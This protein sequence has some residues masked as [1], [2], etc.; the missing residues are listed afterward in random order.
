M[1]VSQDAKLEAELKTLLHEGG[2][3]YPVSTIACF[4]DLI[5]D[6]NFAMDELLAMDRPVI[7]EAV[8]GPRRLVLQRVR[9]E[10]RYW[11]TS[12]R[13]PMAKTIENELGTVASLADAVALCEEFLNSETR[14]GDLTTPRLVGGVQRGA[15]TP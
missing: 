14:P 15:R 2:E 1:M 12:N 9:G 8:G 11:L 7:V 13:E 10:L 4:L 3:R 6:A 5:W